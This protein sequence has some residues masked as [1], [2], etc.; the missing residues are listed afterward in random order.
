MPAPLE[1][2]NGFI[3]DMSPLGLKY[4]EK[5]LGYVKESNWCAIDYDGGVADSHLRLPT[6][7][8]RTVLPTMTASLR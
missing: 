8:D 4:W 6:S 1:A 5:L 3:F 2:N 7:W